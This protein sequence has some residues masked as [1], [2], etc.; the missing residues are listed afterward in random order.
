MTSERRAPNPTRK[1]GQV[2]ESRM[3]FWAGVMEEAWHWCSMEAWEHHLKRWFCMQT[4]WVWC[5]VDS[6]Q[7]RGANPP[8]NMQSTS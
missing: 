3:V 5:K 7:K 8:T 4:A 1:E 2:E 6:T